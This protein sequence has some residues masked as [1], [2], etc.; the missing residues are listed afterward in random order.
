MSSLYSRTD[1]VLA[2][3]IVVCPAPT[4]VQAARV[5]VYVVATSS[6]VL[7]KYGA[8]RLFVVDDP[9]E[10][11]YSTTTPFGIR[12]GCHT[13]ERVVK[14]LFSSFNSVMGPGTAMK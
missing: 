5:K 12:G 13:N 9:V 3:S 8:V 1:T 4:K 2:C 11:W 7:T 6:P 14:P 10:T